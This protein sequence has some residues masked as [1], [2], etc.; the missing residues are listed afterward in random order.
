[1]SNADTVLGFAEAQVGKPYVFGAGGPNEYD[2]SGLT[3]AAY[4]LIGVEL[5]HQTNSQYLQ[6]AHKP[7]SQVSA[8]DLLFFKR[9]IDI[10]HVA[11]AD[12]NGGMISASNEQT[13]VQ[14]VAIWTTDLMDSVGAMPGGGDVSG[15][16]G[17]PYTD[18]EA[19][20]LPLP[21]TAGQRTAMIAWL[22]LHV[23]NPDINAMN[24]ASD[25]DLVTQ[26]ATFYRTVNPQGQTLNPL[27]WT[28]S[29]VGFIKALESANTWKRVGMFLAG[30]VLVGVGVNA[31]LKNNG[32]YQT[33]K[34]GATA[35]A[36]P[37]K[38]ATKAVTKGVNR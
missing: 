34:G 13:G 26:Y 9:G 25:A 21:L 6:L 35:F 16:N 36:M 7:Y 32:G 27:D 5:I 28:G 22:V 2:C 33:V 23:Q 14:H 37:A 18:T 38:T 19:Q 8:G 29:L 15:A 10:Y 12:G 1:M 4:K 17:A 24:S 31:L 30:G 20:A 11:I 3:R